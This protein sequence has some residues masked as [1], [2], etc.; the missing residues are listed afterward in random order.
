MT[1]DLADLHGFLGGFWSGC[2]GLGEK[3]RKNV[4][5]KSKNAQKRAQSYTKYTWQGQKR[6]QV[7][8]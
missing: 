2:G 6:T 7:D 3:M 4:R 8:G 1:V 5:K